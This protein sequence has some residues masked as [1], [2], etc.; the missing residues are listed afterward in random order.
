MLLAAWLVLQN[1]NLF[2]PAEIAAPTELTCHDGCKSMETLPVEVAQQVY[3]ALTFKDI[4]TA[5]PSYKIKTIVLDAGH[6]GKDPGCIGASAKEKDN[7]LAIV[8]Q[9]GALIEANFPDIRV[10][11]TR[12]SDV[13]IELHERAAIANR[14]KADLFISVHC[15]A[16]GAASIHGAETYVLGLHRMDDNLEVA[17]RENASIFYEDDYK[18]QYGDYDP[19]SPEAHILSSYWQSAYLEQSILM[20]QYVQQYAESEASRNNK[21]VKQAGFLVLRETAM[22]SVLVETGYLTNSDEDEF[23]ASEEGRDQ[24]SMAIFKAVR[25]YKDHMEGGKSSIVVKTPAKTNVKPQA[26]QTA[27]KTQATASSGR[28]IAATPVKKSPQVVPQ[29]PK[30]FRIFLLAWPNRLDPNAG[31]LA[32]LS[33]VKE[34]FK[35]GKYHYYMGSY[36]TREEAEKVLPEIKNLGFKTASIVQ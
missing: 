23:L 34:E 15:N 14:E 13:F 36:Q 6:G 29:T 3:S 19:D 1:F 10:V 24:I 11:Y 22:P 4:F 5:Q 25:A 12:D 17:K 2:H 21:G 26:T 20:A 7:A 28:E 16:V 9:V 30:G 18:K 27:V 31:Q 33:H 32:L 8:L 35:E